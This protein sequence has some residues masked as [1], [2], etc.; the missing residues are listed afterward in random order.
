[1]K[2]WGRHTGPQAGQVWER[3]GDLW[4]IIEDIRYGYVE[5]DLDAFCL[6][7]GKR[8]YWRVN[9]LRAQQEWKQVA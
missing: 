8:G 7:T 3:K 2:R 4:L 1:M 6:T 5:W 9:D